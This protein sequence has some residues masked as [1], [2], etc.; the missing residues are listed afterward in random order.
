MLT[1]L[2]VGS[3]ASDE[4][5]NLPLLQLLRGIGNVLI[6]TN[7]SINFFFYIF[8]SARMRAEFWRMLNCAAGNDV[9]T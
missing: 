3:T 5:I 4:S 8:T 2:L 7:H 6:I 1:E 9:T